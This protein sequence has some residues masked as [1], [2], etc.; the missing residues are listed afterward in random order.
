M[1]LRAIAGRTPIGRGAQDGPS[2][3]QRPRT[4]LAAWTRRRR[5]PEA[6]RLLEALERH[7]DPD[8]CTLQL[9]LE[10]PFY[11][12]LPWEGSGHYDPMSIGQASPDEC[13]SRSLWWLAAAALAGAVGGCQYSKAKKKGRR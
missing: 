8:S 9:V 10:V 2:A 4:G 1:G 5:H 12:R 13:P 6:K 11:S 7:P 3:P